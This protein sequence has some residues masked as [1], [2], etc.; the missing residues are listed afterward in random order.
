MDRE[1]REEK[2]KK[3]TKRKK[4]NKSCTKFLEIKKPGACWQQ[5]RGREKD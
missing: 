2:R 5:Q 3:R 4:G 1:K